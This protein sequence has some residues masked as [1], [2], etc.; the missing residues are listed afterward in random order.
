MGFFTQA[1]EKSGPA[2]YDG[3]WEEV[4][5]AC[6]FLEGQEGASKGVADVGAGIGFAE[7]GR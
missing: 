4:G 7:G 5:F 2:A 3:F 6:G 1:R